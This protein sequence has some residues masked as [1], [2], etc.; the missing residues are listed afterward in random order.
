MARHGLPR[1]MRGCFAIAALALSLTLPAS[2][3][4]AYAERTLKQGSTGSDVKLLQRYLTR[5]G[6]ATGADG[7]FGRQTA[8]AQRRWERSASRRADGRATRGEQR[9]V[10]RAAR[11]PA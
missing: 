4:A 10:R 8:A 7:H 5:A 2:A 1:R 3:H 9:L 6:F 11:R